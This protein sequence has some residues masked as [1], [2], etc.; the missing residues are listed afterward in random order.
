M[1]LGACLPSLAQSPT[2]QGQVVDA[3]TGT[4]L[5]G[6]NLTIV[7]TPIGTVTDATGNFSITAPTSGQPLKVSLVGYTTQ[8]FTVTE[9]LSVRI[10]LE[11]EPVSL[12]PVVVSASREQQRRT[13]TPVAIS[14]ISSSVVQD[15]KATAL[16]Q[17]INKVSGV[18]MVNLGNE[19]HTMAIRQPI[20]YNALYIYLEDGLPIRPTGI[21]NHNALYE[22]N[23]AGVQD[24]EVIKGPASSLYG[25]NAIGGAINFTTLKAQASP[26]ARVSLQGDNYGYRRVDVGGGKTFGKLGLY[27]GGYYARQRNSW[28]DYTDFDKFSFNLRADYQLSTATKLTASATY[29]SLDTQTPGN[30]DSAH[31]YSRSYGSNQR[32]TYR[33][34]NAFR[35]SARLEHQWNEQNSTFV[36]LF[37][38]NNSTGQLPSY[39]ISDERQ[40]GQYVRS[41]GQE[42]NQSF[43]SYG[44]LAQ[45]RK[46]SRFLH[47]RLIVGAYLDN[48]PNTYWAKYLDIKKD[49]ANNYYTGF[50]NTDSLIDDYKIKL[51]NYALYAQYE[52]QLTTKLRVVAGLRYDR[53]GY[54][55][56][57]GLPANRTRLKQQQANQYAVLAPKIGFTYDLAKGR[58]LYGN[59]STGFQPPETSSLYSSRQIKPLKQANFTNYELGGWVALLDNKMYLE[60]TVYH[61]EGRDEIISV[62]QA[63]NTTQN[64]NVGITRHQ[65]IEYALTYAPIADVNVRLSGTNAQ[66]TF[67]EYSEVR[68]NFATGQS[69]TVD[70]S[71]NRINNAPRWIANA[72]VSYKPHSLPG[73]RIS[74]E[75]Q[76]LGQY[77]TNNANTKTYGGYDLLNLRLGYRFKQHTLRGL[78]VWGNV[79]NLTNVLYAT[80]VLNNQYGDSYTA[81]SPRTCTVGIGYNLAHK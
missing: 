49:V 38:R 73:A 65:G 64:E 14:K 11:P 52:M 58:G 68:T 47:S 10:S 29:N 32:F 21:F 48:S 67:L 59:V 78:E 33:K 75:C 5:A 55:F 4:P 81:A 39:Y 13:E 17:L 61:L 20:T 30:L 50:T 36:T 74:L 35:T 31:F 19:Q 9:N 54:D 18:Y 26:T 46:D 7:H 42:N 62:L 43:H 15:T 23:M 80:T 28:Q 6:V 37:Y 12:Q 24:I 41:Y 44:L 2:M 63:D 69:T 45:H 60:A 8:I 22:I 25:S 57:N 56:T 16:Y 1:W 77:Y 34:V 53:I 71:G 27:A 66:H 70:F 76:H 79:V 40:N 51:L 3:Q 72:E